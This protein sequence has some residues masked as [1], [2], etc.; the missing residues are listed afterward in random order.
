MLF[1]PPLPSVTLLPQYS[2]VIIISPNFGAIGAP[3]LGHFNE[4]A[5]D[6]ASIC[7]S[8]CGCACDGSPPST[9]GTVAPHL[10][11]NLASSGS[12]APH[13]RQ[14]MTYSSGTQSGFPQLGQNLDA[15]VIALPQLGQFFGGLSC[16]VVDAPQ[17][18]QNFAPA[19]RGEPH[20]EQ[21]VCFPWAAG[22]CFGALCA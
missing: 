18:G 8:L 17:L 12:W 22:C 4:V 15:V 11:Q 16:C 20:W 21:K 3:Q 7:A 14:Y 1:H 6:G 9:P 13:F 10:K 5:L 19:E 2:Q